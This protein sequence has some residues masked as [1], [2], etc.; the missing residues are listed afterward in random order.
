MAKGKPQIRS[1]SEN[2]ADYNEWNY[3]EGRKWQKIPECF[4]TTNFIICMYTS[5]NIVTLM[6]T[7]KFGEWECSMHW[8]DEN[9]IWGLVDRPERRRPFGAPSGRWEEIIVMYSNDKK[10]KFVK[11]I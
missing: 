10:R 2:G 6:K 11:C 3:L 4:M 9:C 8:K 5:R 7:R 1:D